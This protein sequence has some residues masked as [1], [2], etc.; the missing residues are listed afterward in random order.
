MTLMDAEPARS[1]VLRLADYQIYAD[2]SWAG[3]GTILAV[4]GSTE[5]DTLALI[6]VSDPSRSGVKDVLWLEGQRARRRAVLPGL[7]GHQPPLHLRWHRGKRPRCIRSTKD[8]LG[9][10]KRVERGEYDQSITSLAFSPDGRYLLFSCD[11]PD[12]RVSGPAAGGREA[13]KEGQTTA[14]RLRSRAEG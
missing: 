10:A 6:D 8:T 13:A 7:L 14:R 11:G 3:K 4:I 2:P 9:P 1:G 12:R 5:A